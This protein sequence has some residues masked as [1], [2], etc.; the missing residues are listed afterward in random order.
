MDVWQFISGKQL[1]SISIVLLYVLKSDGSSPGR[2]GFK[3]AVSAD[4]DFCGSVGGGIM[5]HK[6]V[7]M[8]K[9]QLK[10]N[11][12]S[13]EVY[14][15][16]HNKRAASNQSGMICSGE[17]TIFL[18]H[19]QNNDLSQVN[20]LVV[21]LENNFN[22]TL[23][24]SRSG[25]IFLNEVPL[26][27]YYFEQ[28]DEDFLL[29]E[30]TGYKNFLHIIGGGHCALALSKLMRE[31]DFYIH[32]YDERDTLNTMQQNTFAH[33]KTLVSSYAV[34]NEI[35]PDNDHCYVVIM[36]LG[37]RSDYEAFKALLGKKIKYTGLLGSSKKIEKLFADHRKEN[38]HGEL[39]NEI[40]APAGMRIKSQT[41]SE[42]AVSIAAEIIAIKNKD[43]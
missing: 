22:G 4:G 13:A 17:Q 15:Q 7:E 42:I 31:L 30:K 43:Q 37:Y 2:Q 36:T 35:I 3:M 34:L 38:L 39:L 24:L 25:I 41:P 6:F 18:Y 12:Q 27:D 5:E 33:K 9:A 16:V 11:A 23:K 8:A 28:S 26:T 10:K 29:V 21:S 1:A 19:L 14:K 32:V 20:A 40:H